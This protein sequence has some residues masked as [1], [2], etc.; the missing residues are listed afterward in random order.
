[1]I[2]SSKGDLKWE[3]DYPKVFADVFEVVLDA[4]YSERLGNHPIKVAKFQRDNVF[5]TNTDESFL[6]LNARPFSPFLFLRERSDANY[7]FIFLQ[8]KNKM[9]PLLEHLNCKI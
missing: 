2:P 7:N 6:L 1:M 4:V 8:E 3:M 5:L 9:L